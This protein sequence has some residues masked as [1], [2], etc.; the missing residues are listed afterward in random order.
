[1]NCPSRTDELPASDGLNQSPNA[2]SNDLTTN[3][4]LKGL[5]NARERRDAEPPPIPGAAAA[6][7]ALAAATV[8]T[9]PEFRTGR[10]GRLHGRAKAL[11]DF[12]KFVGPGFMIAVAYSMLPPFPSSSG[13]CY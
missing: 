11:V 1:M 6:A 7:E 5:A 10:G 2:L 3:Q 12:A 4:D 9:V 8:D 13:D